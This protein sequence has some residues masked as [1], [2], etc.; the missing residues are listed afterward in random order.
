M[1][2][3][4]KGFTLIELLVVIAIIGILATIVL[5]SLNTARQKA[6]DAR[7]ISDLRQVQLALQMYYDSNSAYPSALADL[8]T[9]GFMSAAPVDPSNVAYGYDSDS[10]SNNNYTLG[11]GLEADGTS[12]DSDIDT[13]TQDCGVGTV[14][15][16]DEDPTF[17]YCVQP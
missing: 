12:L 6:R 10:C 14:A 1:K 16:A 8:V 13:A 11:V 9:S 15:C 3:N 2:K 4:K 7:R 5:V 17:G